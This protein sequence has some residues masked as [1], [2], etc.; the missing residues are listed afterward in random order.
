MRRL[1]VPLLVALLGLP[2]LAQDGSRIEARVTF[3]A[4]QNLYLEAGRDA[5]LAANDTLRAFRADQLL[6]M[7]AVISTTDERAVVTFV[8]DLFPVTL[9]D[10][11]TLERAV[12]PPEPE[13]S[14]TPAQP[15]PPV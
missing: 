7:L 4:G 9:G 14:V 11:L 15:T 2:V 5:G 12:R 1:L 10:V 3:I 6:G 13:P 8:G